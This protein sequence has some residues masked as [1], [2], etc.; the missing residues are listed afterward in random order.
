[1]NVAVC[2]LSEL[3]DTDL[4]FRDSNG[5][6]IVNTPRDCFIT[7]SCRDECCIHL[8]VSPIS[9]HSVSR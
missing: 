2:N 4:A 8:N 5:L 6:I 9:V 3:M 1:M 7:V